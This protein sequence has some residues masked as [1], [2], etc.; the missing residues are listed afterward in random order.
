MAVV[1]LALGFVVGSPRAQTTSDLACSGGPKDGQACTS[2][3]D[4]FVACPSSFGACVAVQ[5]VC[6]GG[7]FDGFPCDCPGGTCVGAGTNGTCQGGPL[8]GDP[9]TTTPGSGSCGAGS[10][11]VGSQKVCTGGEFRGFGCLRNTHCTGST[12]AS[13]GRFCDGGDFADF[14]CAVSADC[15]LPTP[16]TS[17]GVCRTPDFGCSAVTPTFTF[18]G[19]PTP[20][21]TPASP[22]AVRTPS[23]TRTGTPVTQ[24]VTPGTQTPSVATPTRTAVAGTPTPT[25]PNSAVVA[26]SAPRGSAILVVDSPESLPLTGTIT[27]IGAQRTCTQFIRRAGSSELAINPGLSEDVPAGT[28]VVFGP[29]GV[30]REFV[31]ESCAV[32]PKGGDVG[33]VWWCGLL[34]L[35]AMRRRWRK[36]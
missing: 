15:M 9:C 36:V 12:C 28:V 23:P 13:T 10:S 25:V 35:W 18:T 2:D 1:V 20:T 21:R 34:A 31:Q 3:D 26:L 17:P 16:Q 30:R 5:G 4:C 8:A 27:R 32:A 14:S 22:T 29:C 33:G 7:E 24:T 19:R 6:D 11:C